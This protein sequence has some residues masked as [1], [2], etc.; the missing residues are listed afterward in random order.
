MNSSPVGQ[1]QGHHFSSQSK[2]Q[3]P[4]VPDRKSTTRLFQPNNSSSSNQSSPKQQHQSSSSPTGSV[5]GG[6]GGG[7]I[8]KHASW[9]SLH[10]RRYSDISLPN[11]A[12]QSPPGPPG[13]QQATHGIPSSG[14]SG[15][16]GSVNGGGTI[17]GGPLPQ[18][19]GGVGMFSWQLSDSRLFGMQAQPMTSGVYGGYM[20]REMQSSSR[21]S[22]AN[23]VIYEMLELDPELFNV[24]LDSEVQSVKELLDDVKGFVY[25]IFLT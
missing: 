1:T 12:T 22:L 4:P 25:Y 23:S 10:T 7:K 24:T 19:M 8:A 17:P 15:G 21:S 18:S 2:L 11:P 16:P 6:G 3:T 13:T 9:N 20:S 5:G 14:F